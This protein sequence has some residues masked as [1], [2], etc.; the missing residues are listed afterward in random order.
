M[1]NPA[2]RQSHSDSATTP[3]SSVPDKCADL[4]CKLFEQCPDRATLD[5]WIDM[6]EMSQLSYICVDYRH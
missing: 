1:D 4:I 5:T 6:V 2:N 3:V